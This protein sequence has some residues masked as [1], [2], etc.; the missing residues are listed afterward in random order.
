[1]I[2]LQQISLFFRALL[3]LVAGTGRF[4]RPWLEYGEAVLLMEVE[5]LPQLMMAGLFLFFSFLAW[6]D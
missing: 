2:G 4:V 3:L 6:T 1:L 5:E